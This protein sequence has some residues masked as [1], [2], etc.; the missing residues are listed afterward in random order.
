MKIPCLAL[1]LL[2]ALG[3]DSGAEDD[4]T[5]P[6]GGGG[7]GGTSSLQGTWVDVVSDSEAIRAIFGA[8]TW[9]MDGLFLL[10]SGRYAMEVMKGTY[11]ASGSSLTLRLTGYSCQGVQSAGGNT[12]SATW[13][14]SGTAL[15]LTLAGSLYLVMQQGGLP[16]GMGSATIG[17]IKDDGTFVAHPVTAVP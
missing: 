11:S 8:S 1:A 7:S 15:E 9:E 4:Y 2:V 13:R 10:N 12:M 5:P 6:T 17:C 3:C 14:R 16:T